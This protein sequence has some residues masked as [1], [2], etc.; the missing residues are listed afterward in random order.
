MRSLYV[1]ALVAV[2]CAAQAQFVNGNF[3]GGDLSGWTITNTSNGTSAS[4][5]VVMLDIDE[6]GPLGMSNAARF[7]VGNLA[8]PNQGQ[9]GI[10]FTQL[11]SLTAGVQY[12]FEFDWKAY[13]ENTT[14]ANSEGGV[15]NLQVDG[16]TIASV[17]AGGTSASL[18]KFGHLVGQ[19]TA[20]STGNHSVGVLIT[21]P[22]T[23]P[24]TNGSPTLYQAVDNFTMSAV[25]EPATLAALGLG[26][27]AFA[28][29]RRK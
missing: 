21:R 26:L 17:A 2:A 4:N 15:F 23:V 9:Q 1:L 6:G 10:S 11:I 20:T 14:T 5:S 3:D 25:P 12:T 29:R 28:R 8:A 27:A 24:I 7:A 16:T 19:F 22:F 13:R 18:P